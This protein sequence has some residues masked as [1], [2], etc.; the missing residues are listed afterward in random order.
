MDVAFAVAYAGCTLVLGCVFTA[1]FFRTGCTKMVSS[2][3]A[4]AYAL[5]LLAVNFLLVCLSV[6]EVIESMVNC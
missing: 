4:W 2:I 1:R 5:F 3:A 6:G